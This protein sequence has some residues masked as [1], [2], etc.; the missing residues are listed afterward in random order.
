MTISAPWE[1]YTAAHRLWQ[2]FRPLSLSLSSNFMFKMGHRKNENKP[3]T[4]STM[5]Q[6]KTSNAK[7]GKG[8]STLALMRFSSFVVGSTVP[9]I[10]GCLAAPHVLPS[11]CH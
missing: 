5:E 7:A 1:A 4:S 2:N 6:T 3:E 10:V 9:C 8:F 11:R